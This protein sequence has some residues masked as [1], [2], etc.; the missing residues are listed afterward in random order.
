MVPTIGTTVRS[1]WNDRIY[2]K[3]VG[4]GTIFV[5]DEVR[6]PGAVIP[7]KPILVVL[8]WNHASPGSNSLVN[9]TVHVLDSEHL[10]VVEPVEREV[11]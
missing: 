1:T 4:Y 2:G 7:D 3:V 5:R 11:V 10:E 6:I 9:P 8:V